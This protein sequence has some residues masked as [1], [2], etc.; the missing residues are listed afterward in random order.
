MIKTYSIYLT[1]NG[2]SAGNAHCEVW[3]TEKFHESMDLMSFSDKDE[4]VE[5][6]GKSIEWA[7][8]NI[9]WPD[10]KIILTE[11]LFDEETE[12]S[13]EKEIDS[14]IQK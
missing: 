13:E 9:T 10:Y 4:A 2:S 8:N 12:E 6:F 3:N 14:F 1:L 5:E 7:K 11:S